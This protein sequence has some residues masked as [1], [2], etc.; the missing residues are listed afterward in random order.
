[1]P[2]SR[3]PPKMRR[4]GKR[5]RGGEDAPA[6]RAGARAY[7]AFISYTRDTDGLLAPRLEYAL[8]RFAP[9]WYRLRAFR[10][11]RDDASLS[12][13]PGLWSSLTGALDGVGYCI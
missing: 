5:G 4:L 12:T 2:P 11:F 6:G 1:M 7:A 8:E 10:I 13:N 3:Q 9:P